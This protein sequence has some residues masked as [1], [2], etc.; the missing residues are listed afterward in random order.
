MKPSPLGPLTP[1]AQKSSGE[2]ALRP[3]LALT[4]LLPA[5]IVIGNF[6]IGAMTPITDD[7]E[8]DMALID[9]VWRLIQGQRLGTD[10]DDPRGFGFF[11][12]AA[13]IWHLLGP[14]YEVLRTS[15]DLYALMIVICG[16]IV[17]TRQLRHA[18]GLAA[19]FCTTIAFEAS[20]PSIYGDTNNFGMAV[21][22]NR[23]TV[24]GLAVLFVQSFANNPI[25]HG[26]RNHV[27]LL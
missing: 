14:R 2:M 20:G 8:D 7:P 10:F 27:D 6:V 13:A 25:L 15:A 22:Y 24:S 11:Q 12:V 1:A 18:A 26:R 9:H 21:S 19:L 23:L 17:A 3:F 4:L 16:C 5:S